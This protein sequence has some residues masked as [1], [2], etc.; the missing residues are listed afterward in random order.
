MSRTAFPVRVKQLAGTT[1]LDYLSGWRMTVASSALKN[2]DEAIAGIAE[3][4][5][6]L[7]DTAFSSAFKKATGQSPGRYRNS[8]RTSEDSRT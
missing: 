2:S 7:S 6:Y 5:G 4:I 3:R 8:Y 1:P